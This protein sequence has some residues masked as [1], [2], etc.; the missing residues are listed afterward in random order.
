MSS[1]QRNYERIAQAIQYIQQNFQQ[2]PQL[3]EVAAHIHLSPA[4]FQRLFT[5]WVGTSP[6]KF[7]QYISVEHAKK[8]LK[9]E[10]GSIFDATF[11]TGLSSTSRLHDLF[12]Q[13]E[14]MTPAEY[15]HGGQSLTIH[16]QFAETLFGEVLI[17][18]THKGIC[19]LSFVENRADALQQLTAQFPQAE[20]IEQLDA[21]QHSAL[22]LFQK[23]QPQ[24]A[25]IKLHLKGTEFQLKVWQSLLK[26]PMGQ[27]STYGELAKAIEHPKAARAVGTAI[28]SNPVAFLIPCHR[29]IQ[30]TGALGGYEWGTLRKTALIGWEGAQTHAAT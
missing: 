16:Y 28:G 5:E 10:Q 9:Q 2:Q 25:E 11:A 7:L 6:K 21:F 13:I 29:V 22:A 24:L 15:K 27:L 14:G 17:A 19:A 12:I 1:Q 18:S 20:F 4:H 3:D 26:I 23:D 30:S 8:I